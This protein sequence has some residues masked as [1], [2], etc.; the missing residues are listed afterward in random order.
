MILITG[1]TGFIGKNLSRHLVTLGR[2][3]RILLSPASDYSRLPK[4]IDLEVAIS[5]LTDTRSLK[6]AMRDVDTV[7]HLAGSERKSTRADFEN[8]DIIGTRNLVEVA[9]DRHVNR[10]LFLSHIGANKSSAFPVLKA[11]AINEG[12]LM[13]GGLNYTIVRTSAVFGRDDQFTT[14]L[15]KLIR[16]MPFFFLMPDQGHIKL[17]PILVDD[18][19]MCLQM[20][21]DDPSFANQTISLG[22]L[23][24]LSLHEIVQTIMAQIR[25]KRP[26][27]PM[28]PAYLRALSVWYENSRSDAPISVYWLD[29]LA[30]DRTASIDILPRLFG[31]MPARFSNNIQYLSEK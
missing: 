4:G 18:L 31:I 5:S 3:V 23:E 20:A 14:S 22:G 24:Y 9:A 7:I 27:I 8:V 25:K 30:A 15:A 16:R 26:I 2:P 29:Y 12:D 17:Q 1:G 11:K 28:S 6:A 13:Q 10:F 19:V 21:L